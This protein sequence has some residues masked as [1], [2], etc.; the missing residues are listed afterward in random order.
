[1]RID[2]DRA[3]ESR[4]SVAQAGEAVLTDRSRV[5]ADSVITDGQLQL[6]GSADSSKCRSS[7]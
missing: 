2:P 1:M 6:A 4:E 7:R 5:E 3:G